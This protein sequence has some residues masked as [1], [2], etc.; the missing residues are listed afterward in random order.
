MSKQIDEFNKGQIYISAD[1]A[2]LTFER[3]FHYSQQIVW[4][5]I[6]NPEQLKKWYLC[7]TVSLEPNER[8][9]IELRSEVTEYNIRGNVVI[10]EPPY[11]FEYQGNI[12]PGVSFETGGQ[13]APVF[14]YGLVEENGSTLFSV[15]YELQP[16]E[17][18][19]WAPVV[20]VL[21]ERLEALLDKRELPEWSTRFAQISDLYSDK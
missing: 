15:K 11:V 10:W 9:M 16:Q 6:T 17:V 7:S 5:A 20:Q 13:N 4:D 8:G 12:E 3:I 2:T 1:F 21:L 19:N 18:Y 14:R